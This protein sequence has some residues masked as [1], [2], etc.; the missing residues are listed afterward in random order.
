[1]KE[2]HEALPSAHD[3]DHRHGSNQD[4]ALIRVDR[5]AKTYRDRPVWTTS[6]SA[7]N[8]IV[9]LLGPNGAGKTPTL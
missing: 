6:P 8:L 5:L 7:V 9:A 4:R 3:A 1:M 2:Q